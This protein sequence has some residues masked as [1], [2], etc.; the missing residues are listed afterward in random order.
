MPERSNFLTSHQNYKMGFKT[1]SLSPPVTTLLPTCQKWKS[2]IPNKL[3]L[4]ERRSWGR[5]QRANPG[6]GMEKLLLGDIRMK[7]HLD[8]ESKK[9]I[10][11]G[12]TVGFFPKGERF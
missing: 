5:D 9:K 2:R 8:V 1:T 6:L 10:L 3:I 7:Q 11:Q 4:L 12:E